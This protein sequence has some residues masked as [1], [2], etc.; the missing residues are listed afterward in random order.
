MFGVF[1][2][3]GYKGLYGGLG[4]DAIKIRKGIAPKENLMDRMDTTELIANQFRMSQT[5]EKLKRENIRNQREAMDAH[6]MVGRRV[7][8]AIE[9]IGGTMPENIAPVEHIKSVEKRVKKTQPKLILDDKDAG[10]LLQKPSQ[11]S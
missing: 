2:D 10:I 9:E 3:A 1:H 11:Q 4:V 7:R 5:R 6:E 8:S